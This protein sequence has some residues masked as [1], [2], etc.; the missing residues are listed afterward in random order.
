MGAGCARGDKVSAMSRVSLLIAIAL[1]AS[2]CGPVAYVNEVTRRASTS[3]DAARAA[4]ADKFSPYY[5]TRANQYLHQARVAAARADFQGANRFGRLAAEAGDKAVEEA[6][7]VQK[8]PSKGPIILEQNNVAPA[9][10]E[11]TPVA[12]AKDGVAPAKDGGE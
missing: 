3:V 2:A 8:D 4:Q 9:K 11:A 5:W 12:P 1:S 10:G 6:A 7:I